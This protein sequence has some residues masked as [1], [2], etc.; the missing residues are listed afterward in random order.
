MGLEWLGRASEVLG[1]NISVEEVCYVA[2]TDN[3][4]VVG[5]RF[6]DTVK[7]K[8]EFDKYGIK[9]KLSSIGVPV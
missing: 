5:V 2:I 8:E 9:Q 7:V 1:H 3:Y 4:E 6:G